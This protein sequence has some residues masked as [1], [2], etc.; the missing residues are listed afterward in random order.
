MAQ[1]DVYLNPNKRSK[2][3]V[4]YLVD[5]QNELLDDLASRVVVPLA[6]SRS[7]NNDSIDRLT[8]SVTFKD[9]D[10]LLLVP[11]LA[12]IS[13]SALSEPIG[14]IASLRNEIIAAIDLL[15]TGI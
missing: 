11:Q 10:L 3:T 8:L 4:P 9:E 14:S 6:K 13:A 5:V 2:K 1:F 15:V 7:M 12:A